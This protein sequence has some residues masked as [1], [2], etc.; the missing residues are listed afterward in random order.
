MQNV[1][2]KYENKGD[3]EIADKQ[4]FYLFYDNPVFLELQVLE[5]NYYTVSCKRSGGLN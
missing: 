1:A 4:E 5:Q 2:G 3:P